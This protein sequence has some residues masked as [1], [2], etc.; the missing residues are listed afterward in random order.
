MYIF[1]GTDSLIA[2]PNLS[3]SGLHFWLRQELEES[4]S[5][6]LPPSVWSKLVYRALNLH[7]S[8]SSISQVSLSMIRKTGGALN[9]SSCLI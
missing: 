8:A 7:L 3:T 5:V 1:M 4:Q 2:L 6:F 9:T